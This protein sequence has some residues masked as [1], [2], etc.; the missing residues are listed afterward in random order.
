MDAI[1][2]NPLLSSLCIGNETSNSE[3]MTPKIMNQSKP[4]SED[5]LN[6]GKVKL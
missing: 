3:T 1:Q 6:H 5:V 4:Y 2:K